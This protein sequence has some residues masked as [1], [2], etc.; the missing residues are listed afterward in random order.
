MTLYGL[1]LVFARP[2][3]RIAPLVLAYPV[4]RYLKQPESSSFWSRF[5]VYYPFISDFELLIQLID[6]VLQ[7]RDL[8]LV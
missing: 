2:C 7:L 6:C 3:D 1:V 4:V 8:L 5:E